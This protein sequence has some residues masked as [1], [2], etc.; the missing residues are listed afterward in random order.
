MDKK[1]LTAIFLIS[2]LASFLAIA[3]FMNTQFNAQT[4][5]PFPPPPPQS[6]NFPT[7]PKGNEPIAKPGP[8]F[9]PPQPQPS[10][11]PKNKV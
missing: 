10:A 8:N 4:P 2:F 5:P 11:P 7:P 1:T 6:V 9:F 3:L